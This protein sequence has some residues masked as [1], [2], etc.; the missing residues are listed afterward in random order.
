MGLNPPQYLI[1]MHM[2]H[3]VPNSKLGQMSYVLHWW[4][5]GWHVKKRKILGLRSK[6]SATN[7]PV[8]RGY[9]TRPFWQCSHKEIAITLDSRWLWRSMSIWWKAYRSSL[10]SNQQTA[11]RLVE[12]APKANSLLKSDKTVIEKML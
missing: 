9:T 2:G 10:A 3:Y 4:H 8:S 7:R 11:T 6:H 12:T 5:L 1:N